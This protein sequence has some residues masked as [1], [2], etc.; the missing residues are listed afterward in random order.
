EGVDVEHEI[1]APER[2]RAGHGSD[3]KPLRV[4]VEIRMRVLPIPWRARLPPHTFELTHLEDLGAETVRIAV[5]ENVVC[6]AAEVHAAIPVTFD[7]PVDLTRLDDGV[8]GWKADDYVGAECQGRLV[9]A[10]HEIVRGPPEAGDPI[11]SSKIEQHVVFGNGG[12]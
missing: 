4:I 2:R 1:G 6:V 8:V 12:R 9:I 5:V 11:L 10:I 7:D 3:A